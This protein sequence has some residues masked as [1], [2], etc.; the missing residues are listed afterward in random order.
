MRWLYSLFFY[1]I[2]PV[3]LFRL[4][5]RS[6]TLADYRRRVRERLGFVQP[7][8]GTQT[9]LWIHAVSVGEFLAALDL[10]KELQ[11]RYPYCSL[12]VTTTTPSASKQVREKLGD[13]VYHVYA[14][15]DLPDMVKRFLRRIKPCA[16][17][18]V[19]TEIWPNYLHYCHTQGI[20]ALLINGR[21]S[22]RS[23][24]G[25]LRFARFISKTINKFDYIMAQDTADAARYQRLGIPAERVTVT[26]NLKFDVTVADRAR[27]QA[28]QLREQCGVDRP[29]WVAA[30]THDGEEQIIL[31]AHALVRQ[32]IPHSLLIIV[33]RHADRFDTVARL[34]EKWGYQPKRRSLQELPCTATTVYLGDTMGEMETYYGASDVAFVGGSLLKIGGHNML[35]P[36]QLAKPI[37][38][39]PHLFNFLRI[40]DLL[41]AKKALVIVHTATELAEKLIVL[42]THPEERALLGQRAL[43]VVRENRGALH[44]QLQLIAQFIKFD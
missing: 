22:E 27:I 28:K 19:E 12:V 26:G 3:L 36:A 20:K 39:G 7:L 25:Y 23:A 34:C 41:L 17:L 4:H 31:T 9:R 33:P 21:L 10:I 42:L 5:W 16:I 44:K 6:L 29:L 40:R 14:P 2:F 24:R 37:L 13:S 38:S 11:R 43:D 8:S 35:E 1:L 15:Y 18:I 32:R 30:S